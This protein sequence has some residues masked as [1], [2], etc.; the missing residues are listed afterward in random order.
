MV[1]TLFFR[2]AQVLKQMLEGYLNQSSKVMPNLQEQANTLAKEVMNDTS[3]PS[4]PERETTPPVN[5]S[6]PRMDGTEL[7][8]RGNGQGNV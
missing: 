6:Q 4:G 8:I 3:A 2:R 1:L 5:A 7:P